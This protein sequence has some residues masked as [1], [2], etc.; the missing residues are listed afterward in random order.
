ETGP[1]LHE[2][3]YPI[4][5]AARNE[6]VPELHQEALGDFG[7]LWFT[8]ISRGACGHCRGTHVRSSGRGQPRKRYA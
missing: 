3:V 5:D 7:F 1:T 6:I 8:D 4:A 2:A